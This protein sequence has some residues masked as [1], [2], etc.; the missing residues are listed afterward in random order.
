MLNRCAC[1][2]GRDYDGSEFGPCEY[3]ESESDKENELAALVRC[4]HCDNEIERAWPFCAWCGVCQ[5]CNGSGLERFVNYGNNEDTR[6][7][8]ECQVNAY[9]MK[10]PPR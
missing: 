4:D 9:P 1:R 6:P 5:K 2:P 3:C 7:C 8:S 10:E